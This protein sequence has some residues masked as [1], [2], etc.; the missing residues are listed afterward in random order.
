[1]LYFFIVR[2]MRALY[3]DEVVYKI[4]LSSQYS[5]GNIASALTGVRKVG[6]TYF[7]GNTVT[8]LSYIPQFGFFFLCGIMGLIFYD[9]RRNAFTGLILFQLAV[10]ML[11]LF[12]IWLGIYYSVTGFIL[13]DFLMT[14]LSP[15]G[16]LGFVVFAS[17]SRES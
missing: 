9:A 7:T 8:D 12:F 11:V 14:Y 2:P 15:L 1:M 13:S 5:V 10:E 4:L 6:I 3:S 16:C 17:L